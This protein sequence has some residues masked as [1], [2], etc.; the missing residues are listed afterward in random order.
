MAAL[1]GVAKMNKR[2][3]LTAPAISCAHCAMTIKRELGSVEGLKVIDVDVSAKT[4][5]LE[6]ADEPALAR[7]RAKLEEIGYPAIGS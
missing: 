5:E 3:K 7:A 4:I 6:Y 2:I 1:E